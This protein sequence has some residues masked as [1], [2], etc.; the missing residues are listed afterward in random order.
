[1]KKELFL[2]ENAI[3]YKVERQIKVRD[4]VVDIPAKYRGKGV[5]AMFPVSYKKVKELVGC[6]E[7]TPALFSFK[8]ALLSITLFDFSRSPVGPYTEL[9]YATP[10]LYNSKVNIPLLPLLMN[11]FLTNFGLFVF[12]IAQSTKIAIEHGNLVTGYPHNQKLINVEFKEKEGKLFVEA[13]GDSKKILAL[14]LEGFKKKKLIKETYMTYFTKEKKLF[15]IQMNVHGIETRIKK[16]KLTLGDH[17][18]AKFVEKMDISAESVQTIYA[19]DMVEINPV[20][21]ESL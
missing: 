2:D 5:T 7:I 8:K 13:N 11:K 15:R 12:D 18:L 14:D 19:S 17:E 16:C 4:V 20:T 10:V 9:V 3:E 6:T 1:M 21:L